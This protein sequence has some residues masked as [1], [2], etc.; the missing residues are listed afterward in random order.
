M[1]CNMKILKNNGKNYKN[2]RVLYLNN[3]NETGS[4]RSNLNYLVLTA[5]TRKKKIK[6]FEIP[7]H[8]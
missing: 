7:F 3:D 1:I 6:L 8:F 4:L 5:I 2:F